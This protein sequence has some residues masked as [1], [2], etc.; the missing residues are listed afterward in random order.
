MNPRRNLILSTSLFAIPGIYGLYKQQYVLSF[1]SFASMAASINYWRNPVVGSRKNIDLFVSKSCG[2]IY[3]IYG[4]YNVN[5]T[6]L[7]LLGYTNCIF[8]ASMYNT[9]C[10]LHEMNSD[11]WELYHMLFHVFGV[12][13]KMLVISG[14]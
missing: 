6:Y 14:A 2:V 9:S 10:I 1:T 12:I 3:F 11:T 4:Y 13:G 5:T 7:R 8:T